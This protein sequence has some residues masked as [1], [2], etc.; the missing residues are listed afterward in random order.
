[1]RRSVA[2]LGLPLMMIVAGCAPVGT[3]P[4]E[5]GAA[6]GQSGGPKDRQGAFTQR[7]AAVAQAWQ[8][9]DAWT[10]GFVPLQEPTVLVGDPD[11]TPQTKT[12]FQAGWYRATVD[13]PDRKPADGTVRFPDGSARVPLVSAAQAYREL[14]QGDPG[15]CP[16][17]TDPAIPP[18]PAPGGG[19]DS[20]V[21]SRPQ[22]DCVALTVTRVEL[23]TAPVH[24]ARGAAQVPAWLFT[25]P[26]IGAV[27]ARVAVAPEAVATPPAPVPPSETPEPGLVGAQDIEAVEGTTLRHRLGVGS[28]DT[29]ITPLVWEQ[30]HVIVVGGTVVPPTG[31]CDEMLNLHPAE[32][33][34]K[35][36]VG[37]RPV[38]DVL[39]GSP[40]RVVAG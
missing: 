39:S 1:M 35:A 10:T 34:L 26:E 16:G 23:G 4:D 2:L 14:R 6:S 11:F 13:L 40:L 25:V 32:V 36:P 38:L 27:V 8:P 29:E 30:D 31:G 18:A 33:T 37:A 22:G 21:G 9:D 15:A 12:A 7:A 24:T 20:A 19:P 28:C 17:P 5:S 3:E